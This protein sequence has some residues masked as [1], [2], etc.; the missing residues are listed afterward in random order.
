MGYDWSFDTLQAI[1]G[2]KRDVSSLLLVQ[3]EIL[4][5]MRDAK[6]AKDALPTAE[7]A[8][9]TEQTKETDP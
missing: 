4:K 3:K 8:E 5:I 1:Q 7:P 6:S 2:V 9:D